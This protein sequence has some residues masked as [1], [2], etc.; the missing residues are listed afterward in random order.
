MSE[1]RIIERKVYFP[2]N[3]IFKEGDEGDR[4]YLL[5]EGSVEIVSDSAGGKILAVIEAGAL[6]GEMAL[7][8]DK[9][10]M[11]TARAKEQCTVIIVS[12]QAFQEK[13]QKA[14]PFIRGLLKIFVNNI[15]NMASKR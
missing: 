2:G 10:R 15:R 11:A 5:Q 3:V 14:D 12:R 6:F 8:D 1:A 13:L 9:P 7:V 4:A